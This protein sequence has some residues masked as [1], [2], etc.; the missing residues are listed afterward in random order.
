M[1]TWPTGEGSVHR[2]TH[3]WLDFNLFRPREGWSLP[4]RSGG[5]GPPPGTSGPTAAPPRKDSSARRR[6]RRPELRTGPT[7]TRGPAGAAPV[8]SS[9]G[10]GRRLYRPR[11]SRSPGSRVRSGPLRP[12]GASSPANP[13]FRRHLRA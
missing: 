5:P 11:R 8:H 1:R 2:A 4:Q 10:A 12:G 6:A 3:P 7:A 13:L 9:M